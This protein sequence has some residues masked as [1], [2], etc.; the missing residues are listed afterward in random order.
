MYLSVGSLKGMLWNRWAAFLCNKCTNCT[1]FI[2]LF[3]YLFIFCLERCVFPW[4]NAVSYMGSPSGRRTPNSALAPCP[5]CKVTQA[6]SGM[7]QSDTALPTGW[8]RWALGKK[9]ARHLRCVNVLISPRDP[10]RAFPFLV[11]KSRANWTD[12]VPR[13]PSVRP[14]FSNS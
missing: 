1:L 5:G 4:V 14:S 12:L 2:Y 11:S 6:S 3:I 10:S 7:T 8:K 9:K 13:L